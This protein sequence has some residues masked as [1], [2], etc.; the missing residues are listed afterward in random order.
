MQY[1]LRSKWTGAIVSVALALILIAAIAI[2]VEAAASRPNTALVL[3]LGY[4]RETARATFLAN[5]CNTDAGNDQPECAVGQ[6]S[7]DAGVSGRPLIE[8]VQFAEAPAA[9]GRRLPTAAFTLTAE[10]VGRDGLTV[11]ATLDPTDLG[12]LH[13]VYWGRVIVLRDAG[14]P[15]LLEISVVADSRLNLLPVALWCLVVGAASGLT[16]RWFNDVGA[17]LAG[18]YRKLRRLRRLLS[19]DDRRVLSTDVAEEFADADEALDSIDVPAFTARVDR[20][21]TDLAALKRVA[22]QLR[23]VER[24]ANRARELVDHHG[25]SPIARSARRIAYALEVLLRRERDRSW[26]WGDAGTRKARQDAVEHLARVAEQLDNVIDGVGTEDTRPV[27]LLAAIARRISSD[28]PD[29]LVEPGL[30]DSIDSDLDVVEPP[31]EPIPGGAATAAR[32]RAASSVAGEPD[33]A[34][35]DHETWAMRLTKVSG[36][37]P[38]LSLLVAVCVSGYLTRVEDGSYSGSLVDAIS[39]WAWAFAVA[40]TGGTVV[41]VLGQ[42]TTTRPTTDP[43]RAPS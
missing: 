26:P 2:Q 12:E 15:I 18:L 31:P 21:E 8:A 19:Q 30:M 1:V 41:S 16:V 5:V 24:T 9:D 33:A 20:I 6:D 23:L 34:G 37:M 35:S 40:V 36:V 22:K 28:G 4:G 42:L 3:D 11:T 27:R 7:S 10:S 17:P 43:A 25:A 32:T 38:S 29:V 14:A 39:L 13:G